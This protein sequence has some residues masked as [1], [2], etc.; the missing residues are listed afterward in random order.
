M[1]NNYILNTGRNP[2]EAEMTTIRQQAWELL[3][4]DIAFEDQY[5]DLGLTVSEDEK[6]DMVQGNNIHPDL[7]RAFTNPETGEFDKSQILNF[8][9]NFS[10]LPPQNQQQWLAMEQSIY[11][12]RRR[13]KYDNL[14]LKTNYITDA[15]AKRQY[16]AENT[17]AEVKYLYVPF[18]AVSDS[19]VEVTDDELRD[20]IQEHAQEYKVDESRSLN[21]ITIP[22]TASDEDSA[23]YKEELARLTKDFKGVKND[24]SFAR[25]NSDM[26]QP[27][28]SYNVSQLPE[29]L[30]ENYNQLEEGEVY[31]P[32]LENGIYQLYKVSDV[33]EDTVYSAKASHI[34]FKADPSDKEASQQAKQKAQEALQELQNGADFADLAR[35]KSEDGSAANG[36]D[37]GWF[38][39]GRMV[40]PFSDAVFGADKPGLLNKVVETQFGYHIIKVT[41]TKTNKAFKIASIQR[42][43]APSDETRDEAFRKADYF[44]GMTEDIEDFK[45][46]AA[47]DSLTV[48]EADNIAS[49]ARRVGSMTNARE[50]VRWLFR[51]ASVGS[52][53][54]V[55]E[56]DDAYVVAVMTGKVEEGVAPLSMVKPEVT[57]KVKNQKKG[58]LILD[59]LKGLSGSLDEM[60]KAYGSDAAVHST[61]DLKLSSNSLPSVGFAP[62][63]V[64]KAFGLKAGERSEPF[65]DENGALVI[66]TVSIN[67]AGEIADYSS[68]KNTLEQTADNRTSYEISQ[69]IKENANIEDKRYKFF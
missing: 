18:Y 60:A 22:I 40:E 3:I 39:E 16:M 13:L 4:V 23:S 7:V 12:A 29:K 54:E 65:V 46:N 11:Q 52:V 57:A 48:L 26:G 64:G 36:G 47:R 67:E 28:R 49:D 68:Y 15:E 5:E 45:E 53:S 62:I 55:F 56:L 37:L 50:I 25:L 8:L 63:A 41:E 51:D 17:T 31:G 58:Q 43:V 6:V 27:Y 24:S 33:Y 34:L 10:Q 20:Y 42:E 19:A 1:K 61:P 44:A 38:S 2:S 9:R 66:E 69:A 30:Q 14:F 32:Y 59:K 35:N 21:Y